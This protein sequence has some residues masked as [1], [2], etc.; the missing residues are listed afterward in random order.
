[1]MFS[2]SV[3]SLRSASLLLPQ[4]QL[5]M[6]MLLLILLRP[7]EE[8]TRSSGQP[9]VDGL[10]WILTWLPSPAQTLPFS[11]SSPYCWALC[12]QQDHTIY[13]PKIGGS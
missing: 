5:E 7:R 2:G 1:M 9:F 12:V 10:S 11:Y 4:K 3:P 13:L 8:M 6:W